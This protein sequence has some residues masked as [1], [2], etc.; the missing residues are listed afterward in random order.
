MEDFG[1]GVMP[2]EQNPLEF[3]VREAF[4]PGGFQRGA[5]RP[6]RS[7]PAGMR[8]R[9]AAPGCICVKLAGKPA[10][11]SWICGVAHQGAVGEI[12][13][14]KLGDHPLLAGV[15]DDDGQIVVLA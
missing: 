8:P 9:A 10:K 15:E 13:G 1:D 6:S 3:F 11:M 14:Q 2:G 12:T 4:L 7:S 5:R